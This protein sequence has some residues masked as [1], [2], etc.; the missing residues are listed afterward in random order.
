MALGGWSLDVSYDLR[1]PCDP[2][3]R[4]HAFYSELAA[5]TL[6]EMGFASLT[7]RPV[8]DWPGF[9]EFSSRNPFSRVKCA[10]S[11]HGLEMRRRAL[12]SLRVH[13]ISGAPFYTCRN[14]SGGG[15]KVQEDCACER[16]AS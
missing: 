13:G 7:C 16:S 1:R 15:L 8:A 5:D 9:G 14:T 6:A 12:H 2:Q 3:L 10:R 11:V 4:T